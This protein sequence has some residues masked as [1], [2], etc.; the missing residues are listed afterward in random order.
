MRDKF[1]FINCSYNGS[2]QLLEMLACLLY[3]YYLEITAL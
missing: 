3:L 2:V 1:D